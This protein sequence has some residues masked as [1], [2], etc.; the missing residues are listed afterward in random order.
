MELN[1]DTD[2][3]YLAKT[4]YYLPFHVISKHKS[5]HVYLLYFYSYG[6]VF[7]ININSYQDISECRAEEINALIINYINSIEPEQISIFD[8]IYIKMYEYST[9]RKHWLNILFFGGD[10]HEYN[11]TYENIIRYNHY[12]KDLFE[13]SKNITLDTNPDKYNKIYWE[14]V[15]IIYKKQNIRNIVQLIS[16]HLLSINISNN[17]SNN[18]CIS[19]YSNTYSNINNSFMIYY[20]EYDINPPSKLEECISNNKIKITIF[21]KLILNNKNDLYKLL[22]RNEN[23]ICK[24]SIHEDFLNESFDYLIIVSINCGTKEFI[25]GFTKL[26]IKKFDIKLISDNSISKRQRGGVKKRKIEE[27][28]IYEPLNNIPTP[29]S[30]E[31]YLFISLLCSEYPSYGSFIIKL[32]NEE[33]VLNSI[34]ND[35]KIKLEWLSLKALEKVYMYYPTL[36]FTRNISS[37]M[38]PLLNING[39]NYYT[40]EDFNKDFKNILL[41]EKYDSYYTIS[42]EKNKIKLSPITLF[43]TDSYEDGYFFTKKIARVSKPIIINNRNDEITLK[44]AN[45]KIKKIF[46]NLLITKPIYIYYTEPDPKNSI[47]NVLTPYLLKNYTLDNE[48]YYDNDGDIYMIIKEGVFLE[49]NEKIQNNFKLYAIYYNTINEGGWRYD[50]DPSNL[51]DNITKDT[52]LILYYNENEN[53]KNKIQFNIKIA[54]ATANSINS[55]SIKTNEKKRYN[56]YIKHYN[57]SFKDKELFNG[58]NYGWKF[59]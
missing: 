8:K 34:E 11:Y 37:G 56:L 3:K 31:V 50:Y 59:L 54:T 49:T 36:G 18:S 14:F 16:D 33:N 53:K 58:N 21:N 26:L 4:S 57:I 20:D 19:K 7:E 55:I 47:K 2:Y 12:A 17:T 43:E 38:Y 13:C 46:D 51:F 6:Y 44:K 10:K 28:N 45:N 27:T 52:E 24:K 35:S 42:S 25:I 48:Y 22:K 41:D 29:K 40:I 23:V 30:D 39:K 1:I 5:K 15:S 32:L 9:T